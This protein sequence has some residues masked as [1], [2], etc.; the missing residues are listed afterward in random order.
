MVALIDDEVKMYELGRILWLLP[1][2]AVE[3]QEEPAA[4]ADW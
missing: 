2:V 1:D 4:K 3:L